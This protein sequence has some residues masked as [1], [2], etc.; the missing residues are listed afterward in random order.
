M[1]QIKRNRHK[2]E[3]STIKAAKSGVATTGHSQTNGKHDKF[4]KPEAVA[5]G[6]ETT[7]KN[8]YREARNA[9]IIGHP[10]QK[11]GASKKSSSDTSASSSTS[12]KKTLAPVKKKEQSSKPSLNAVK[13]KAKTAPPSFRDWWLKQPINKAKAEMAHL[14]NEHLDDGEPHSPF[15]TL[16]DLVGADVAHQKTLADPRLKEIAKRH[17]VSLSELTDVDGDG[18]IDVDDVQLISQQQQ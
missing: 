6:R 3:Q 2:E 16:G 5:G 12:S 13:K 1:A 11:S 7:D 8:E 15:T 14:E 18:D 17:G 4:L 10:S 9:A